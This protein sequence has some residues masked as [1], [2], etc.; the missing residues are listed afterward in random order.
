MIGPNQRAPRATNLILAAIYGALVALIIG[1]A[2]S[3]VLT[4]F[5]MGIVGA[6]GTRVTGP[7]VFARAGLNLYAVQ[8]VSL[9][10]DGSV[11]DA[12]GNRERVHA[13][14]TLPL[15]IWAGIPIVALMVGG[16]A[17]ARTRSSRGRIAMTT[18]ALLTA[19]L[20]AIVLAAA[21]V[22][23]VARIDTFLLPEVGGISSN[24]PQ[25]P[26]RPLPS[27]A[28]LFGAVFGFVFAYLGAVIAARGAHGGVS[29]NVWARL[30]AVV[31]VALVVQLLIAACALAW[32]VV[33]KRGEGEQPRIIEM[34]PMAAGIGYV[35]IHGGTLLSSVESKVASM[36][37]VDRPFC[38]RVNLYGGVTQAESHKGVPAAVWGVGLAIGIA[39][40]VLMGWL[41][42]KWGSRDGALATALWVAILHTFYLALLTGLCGMGL[43]QSGAFATSTIS[44]EPLIGNAMFAS[45]GG[46]FVLSLVGA[47]LA[48]KRCAIPAAATGEHGD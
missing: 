13:E 29:R 19:A 39:A 45:L 15:T 48:G 9:A 40:A 36:N 14:I 3:Y 42:V 31:I 37:R 6:S 34:L 21:S 10:G 24:P 41:A 18:A 20:Y 16:Y 27:S 11:T 47:G 5:G 23:V 38:A 25:I 8:H 1:Y 17:A 30:K 22:W 4:R 32:S 44:V 7:S 35:M 43:S 33:R 26:F 46:T 12:L 28:L 2:A